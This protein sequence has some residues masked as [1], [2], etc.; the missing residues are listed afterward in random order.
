MIV[1]ARTIDAQKITSTTLLQASELDVALLHKCKLGVLQYVLLKALSAMAV[2]ISE[3]QLFSQLAMRI[4]ANV[5]Q[6]WTHVLL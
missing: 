6:R 2:M 4:V 3:L 5:S 1:P